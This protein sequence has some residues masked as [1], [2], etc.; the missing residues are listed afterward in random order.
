SIATAIRKVDP[1]IDLIVAT[2][3]SLPDLFL[4][5]GIETVK[6]PSF[7]SFI[8]EQYW[9]IVPRY[10]SLPFKTVQK[11]RST[12]LYS[13]VQTFQPNLILI[14]QSPFGLAGELKKVLK[15]KMEGKLNS[16][17]GLVTRGIGAATQL[18]KPNSKEKNLFKAI[19]FVFV[20]DDK[21]KGI[22]WPGVLQFLSK[23]IRYIGRT[24]IRTKKELTPTEKARSSLGASKKEF[25][26][27]ISL[28]RGKKNE[29][30]LSSTIK[31]IKFFCPKS[32]I[33]IFSDPYQ[34]LSQNFSKQCTI[35]PFTRYAIDSIA[36]A[37]LVVCRAGYNTISELL[38]T[39]SKALVIPRID[40]SHEQED[41]VKVFSNELN[42]EFLDERNISPKI[43]ELAL[44]RLFGKKKSLKKAKIDK[45][46]VAKK[47]LKIVNQ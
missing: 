1:S 5:E 10:L 46:R 30:L 21:R 9:D 4:A 14:E 8:H 28:G 16:K 6:I 45:Y 2:G 32:K 7:K 24:A 13:L 42:A 15:A 17:I 26:V 35:L 18:Y 38:M 37:D 29:A 3:S 22:F 23:K 41:R 40:Q 12:L 31:G 25:L 20:A 27:V 33:I 43:I 44:Q 34:A 47:I 36:A 19:N 11:M 39:H